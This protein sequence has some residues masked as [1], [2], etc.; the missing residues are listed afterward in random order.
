MK[1]S[2]R[3]RHERKISAP[4]CLRRWVSSSF[5][6]S[7][8]LP[9]FGRG[10]FD[11]LFFSQQPP[12]THAITINAPPQDVWPWIRQIGQDR[13]GFYSYTPLEN[14][15]GC[16]MPTV[17]HVDPSWKER[18]IGETVWFATPKHYRG[19]TKMIAAVVQPERA[20]AVV[21]PKDWQRLQSGGRAQETL[22]AFTL[23]PVGV[24]QTRL[25]A[26]LRGAE[27]TNVSQCLISD[28]FWEPGAPCDG[29]QNVAHHQKAGRIAGLGQIRAESAN[30]IRALLCSCRSSSAADLLAIALLR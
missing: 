28:L 24:G 10:T 4:G 5:S 30:L 6:T 23:E 17:H 8:T 11:E 26:R 25:I 21:T 9:P 22:W 19:Q 2:S 16:Q 20:F 15:V 7:S 13:S 29:T 14:L 3:C 18:A 27:P 12:I 1:G